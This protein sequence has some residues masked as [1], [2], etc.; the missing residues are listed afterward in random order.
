MTLQRGVPYR[1]RDEREMGGCRAGEDGEREEKFWE[2]KD[3]GVRVGG[4]KV[5]GER[6]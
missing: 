2:Q 3:G 4:H 5:G 1:G 6:L